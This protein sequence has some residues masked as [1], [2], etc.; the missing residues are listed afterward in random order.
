[1]IKQVKYMRKQGEAYIHKNSS[2]MSFNM[3]YVIIQL[4]VGDSI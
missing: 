3:T 2:R 4:M 1:M